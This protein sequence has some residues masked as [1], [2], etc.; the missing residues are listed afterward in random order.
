MI[1][2]S[3]LTKRPFL[4]WNFSTNLKKG[5]FLRAHQAP[6]LRKMIWKPRIVFVNYA[7]NTRGPRKKNTEGSK[8]ATLSMKIIFR[9][10]L[11]QIWYL[12]ETMIFTALKTTIL[13]TK[14]LRMNLWARCKKRQLKT[15]WLHH[16][17]KTTKKDSVMSKK[18]L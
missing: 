13:T 17:L 9:K 6:S 4:L 7:R 3:K 1:F 5:L 14:V 2:P 15:I 18:C 11:K 12:S 8:I 16:S 10:K